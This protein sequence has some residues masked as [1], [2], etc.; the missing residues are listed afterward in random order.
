MKVL[1]TGGAGFIGSALCRH[2]ISETGHSVVNV[3][4]MTYASTAG[5][6][7]ALVGH[8]RYVFEQAD[9]TDEDE[10]ARIL[11]EHRPDA[12]ANLAAETHV[13]RSITGA[14]PFI[15]TNIVGAYVMLE[16]ARR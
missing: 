10:I 4:K 16:A 7:A 8:T 15:Q 11:A 6:T 2:L 12:I 1:V 14:A 13:D 9:I 5:S 3:D